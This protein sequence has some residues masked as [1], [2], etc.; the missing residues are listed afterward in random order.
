MAT[1]NIIVKTSRTPR[2]GT[3]S[4]A[5]IRKAVETVFGPSKTRKSIRGANARKKTGMTEGSGIQ[6]FSI[7]QLSIR[8]PVCTHAEGHRIHRI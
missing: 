3:V 5:A 8:R 6:R 4:R 2:K 1:R 7:Y